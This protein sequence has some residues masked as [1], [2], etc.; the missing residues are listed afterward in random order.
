MWN[1]LKHNKNHT[2]GDHII[3]SKV[4][5]LTNLI[6][7]G[8]YASKI[9]KLLNELNNYKQRNQITVT[10]IW[11]YGDS[12]V[13]L[14]EKKSH[15]QQTHNFVLRLTNNFY[16]HVYKISFHF[17]SVFMKNK[18]DVFNIFFQ[19]FQNLLYNKLLHL[20]KLFVGT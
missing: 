17:K 20:V 18:K 8:L 2:F 10:L 4:H 6:T 14:G 16:V 13:V 15:L 1:A 5:Q 9:R 19:Y 12:I 7:L 3:G 11:W